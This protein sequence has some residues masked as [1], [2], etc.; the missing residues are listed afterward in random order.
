MNAQTFKSMVNDVLE[1][2]GA[3]AG[4]DQPQPTAVA[5]SPRSQRALAQFSATGRSAMA[6]VTRLYGLPIHADDRLE[7]D[8][9]LVC[10]EG[11]SPW[12]TVY[13]W[14]NGGRLKQPPK[15]HGLREAALTEDGHG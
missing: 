15:M 7:D 14:V 6:A 3:T 2:I 10:F 13:R 9:W 11:E 8:E 1:S 4:L 12:L 5:I